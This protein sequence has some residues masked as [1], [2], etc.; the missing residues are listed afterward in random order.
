M[1]TDVGTLDLDDR[2]ELDEPVLLAA[3]TGWN[4]AGDA[5]SDTVLR[6]V[7]SLGGRLVGRFD[8]EPYYDFQAS[9]P[10]VELAD[11]VVHGVSWP[12]T[13]CYA[14]EVTNG[15]DVLAIV[16]PEPNFAWRAFADEIV[17]LARTSGVRLALTLGALLAD[18]PHTRPT[19]LTGAVSDPELAARVTLRD[20]GYEGP[21][22]ITGVLHAAIADS[23]LS[24]AS[25]WAPVPHYVSSPPQPKAV[26]AL[27]DATVRLTGL[28]VRAADLDGEVSSWETR[29]DVATEGDT[30]V[31]AYVRSLEER[32]DHG[33]GDVGLDED[34]L[35][36]GDT[37]AAEFQ[38]YLRGE[39]GR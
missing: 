10:V 20:S 27:L 7:R 38:R 36:S 16:G 15:P 23:G 37:L 6:V 8:P 12:T 3:F 1:W 35:P 31:Q 5:A 18:V 13:E 25:L 11:G 9:R 2:P 29:V 34:S 19:T 39:Q 32:H 21:T 4:D 30:E 14:I 24:S 28:P 22:G 33:D 26:R 17:E